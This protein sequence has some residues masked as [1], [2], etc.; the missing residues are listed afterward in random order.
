MTE[1]QRRRKRQPKPTTDLPLTIDDE[2]DEA[3]DDDL[4]DDLGD[5]LALRVDARA[6]PDSPTQQDDESAGEEEEEED[7]EEEPDDLDTAL[8]SIERDEDFEREV[9]EEINRPVEELLQEFADPTITSDPVRMYL[10]EIGRTS[11][12]TGDEEI[13]LAFQIRRGKEAGARLAAEPD[14]DLDTRDELLL[15]VRRGNAA[16]QRLTNANLRLVVS[17][18]KRYIGRGMSFSDLIQEG[19]I[20][21]LRAVQKFDHELGFKFS[22]YA[23]WWIRQAISRAIA[24]QARTIRIPVHMVESINRQVRIQRRLAQELGR[25]PTPEEIALETDLLAPEDRQ[26][27]DAAQRASMTLDP[28]LLRRWQRAAQKV[29]RIS[30]VSQ[31]PMSLDMPVGQEENSYLGDFIEDDNLPGPADAARQP[32]GAGRRGQPPVVARADA[33]HPRPAQP[34]RAGGAGDALW[35]GGR[36]QPHPGGGGPVLRRDPRAHPPDRGQGAAQA[37]PPHPQP[38]AA[39]LSRITLFLTATCFRV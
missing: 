3:L 24:D 30:R 14:L 36:H 25:D 27:I 38:Q 37:A 16:Q 23:T 35:F 29:Q 1:Q 32:A 17:V 13:D 33:G 12:L 31:E 2:L 34:A 26:A 28:E 39:R 11:L 21:L 20:G 19:N 7:F 5:D 6:L 9:E 8:P 10:R 18:A 4:S 15:A 22:T